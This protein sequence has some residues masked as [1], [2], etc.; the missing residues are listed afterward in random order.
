MRVEWV[1]FSLESNDIEASNDIN[2]YGNGLV[3]DWIGS[4]DT[5]E[6]AVKELEWY[7]EIKKNRQYTI[8]KVYTND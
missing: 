4:F 3:L 1:V 7:N 5:E 6:E 2:V 8:L